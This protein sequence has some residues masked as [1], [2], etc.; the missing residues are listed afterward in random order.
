MSK[1]FQYLRNE[2]KKIPRSTIHDKKMKEQ[3]SV[4]NKFDLIWSFG[5]SKTEN[6]VKNDHNK[7]L[8]YDLN[9]SQ[10]ESDTTDIN[11]FYLNEFQ[12]EF[13]DDLE[14]SDNNIDNLVN[15]LD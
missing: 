7:I 2:N 3:K 5:Q 12:S 9:E 1:K 14:P 10:K 13:V 15:L 4:L 11:D 6:L 8:I